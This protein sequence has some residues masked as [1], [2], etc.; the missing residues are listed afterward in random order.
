MSNEKP[1]RAKIHVPSNIICLSLL[2]IFTLSISKHIQA[3]AAPST[4]CSSDTDSWVFQQITEG[5]IADLKKSPDE[6]NRV[7][8]SSCLK[9][10]LTLVI[11]DDDKVPSREVR[12][13]NAVVKERVDIRFLDIPY[14]VYLKDCIFESDVDI[15]GSR[16]Q[17]GLALVSTIFNRTSYFYFIKVS[18]NLVV[19]K[20]IFK[21]QAYFIGMKV[22]GYITIYDSTFE[23]TTNFGSVTTPIFDAREAHFKSAENP[24]SFTNMQAGLIHFD[25]ESFA[26]QPEI[27]GMTYQAF[28]IDGQSSPQKLLALCRKAKFSPSA[29]TQAEAFVRASAPANAADQFFIERRK[30]ERNEG[31]GWLSWLWNLIL[32][33]VVG[34]GRN[35]ERAWY[36]GL[37]VI[38]V[39]YFVFRRRQG[40]TP[41]KPEDESRPYSPFW[42]SVDLFAPVINLK[43]ADT[44]EPARGRWFARNYMYVQRILGWILVPIGIAVWTGILK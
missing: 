7:L 21:G 23:S 17:R 5:K 22:D 18:G 38:A 6:N 27:S 31:A 13:E 15:G 14:A 1:L 40:M 25:L 44:W 12:I 32:E 42:Y 29:Y 41:R 19:N 43:V 30:R 11:K 37:A 26:G 9:H 34:Y 2:I 35:P 20:A 8:S 24:P 3:K 4:I 16:F 10:L 39:G 28:N 36:I 33:K